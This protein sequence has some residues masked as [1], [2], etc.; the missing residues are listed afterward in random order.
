LKIYYVDAENT[1]LNMLD[2][3]TVSTLDR[4]FVFTNSEGI[5]SACSNALLTCVSGYPSGQNQADFYIIAHLSNVLSHLSKAEKKAIEFNLCSKDQNLWKAFEFQCSL[6]GAKSSAPYIAIETE[7]NNVV[8][9][10][11][12]SIEAKILK[13][14]SQPI[15]SIEIQHKLKAPQSEF[16]T[17]FN[18]LIRTG[19]IKRQVNSKK[20]WQRVK[21]T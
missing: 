5:K 8:V 11:D 17:S 7:S 1:G 12:T 16:T 14:M 20:H 4:V 21:S 10:I 2:E 6:S 19:K 9:P 15:T 18:Q 3:L 13:L